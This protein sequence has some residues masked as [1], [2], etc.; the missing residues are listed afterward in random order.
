MLQKSRSFFERHDSAL[1]KTR[2]DSSGTYYETNNNTIEASYRVTLQRARQKKPHTI[3]EN[4]IKACSQKTMLGNEEKK[5]K[6]AVS[7]SDCTV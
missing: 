5:K 7:L 6:A 1:K 2:L 4:L 3:G